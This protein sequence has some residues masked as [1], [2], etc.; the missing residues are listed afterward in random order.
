MSTE[1][2]FCSQC[3]KLLAAGARFCAY[4][5]AP[6]QGAATAPPSPP[7]TGAAPQ[8]SISAPEQAEPII[9]VI[10]LQRRSGFMG[11]TVENFNMI[12][13]PQRLVLIPVSK[14]EMQEAVKTAQEEARAAGKGF[15]GQW[16]A[17]LAWLQVLY[18]KYRTTPVAEL[19]QTPGSVV[20]WNREVRSIR[21]SDPRVVQRGSAT[22]QTSA[23]SQI[24][25]ETTRGGFKFDLLM[26]KAGEARKI[27][28]QTLG[29][30]V[31]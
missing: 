13:T 2:K 11:M 1:A 26:M 30:V 28:Q 7:D 4:C 31:H 3:G 24:A 25:L 10:P 20:L 29:G 27:L 17:Q 5:G 9:D 18:R 23:Y 16:A 22:E 15:F 8:S 6:V 19:A 12:V 21:L 14:Q